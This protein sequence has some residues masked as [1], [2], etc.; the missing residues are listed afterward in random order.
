MEGFYQHF[1]SGLTLSHII[2]LSKQDGTYQIV[3]DS[4]WDMYTEYQSGLE[5]DIELL[6]R[7]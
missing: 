2:R 3:A 1:I 5:E 6:K 4:C 7:R